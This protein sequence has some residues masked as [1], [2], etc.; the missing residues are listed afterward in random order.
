[1]RLHSLKYEWSYDFRR[2]LN[3]YRCELRLAPDLQMFAAVGIYRELEAGPPSGFLEPEQ[4]MLSCA[5]DYVTN[6]ATGLYYAG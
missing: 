3:V 1:M 2:L 4:C 5:A 6:G